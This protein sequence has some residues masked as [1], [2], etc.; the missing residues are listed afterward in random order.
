[1]APTALPINPD[2]DLINRKEKKNLA[3]VVEH[4]ETVKTVSTNHA[5]D[6]ALARVLHGANVKTGLF[7]NLTSKNHD[8]YGITSETYFEMWGKD[9]EDDDSGE[10]AKTRASRYSTLVNAYYNLATDFYEYGW[11]KS[12]HFCRFYPGEEFNSAMKRHEYY[13]ANRLGVEPGMKVLD[14][15]CGVGGPARAIAHLTGANIIGLNNNAY[16]VEKARQYAIQEDLG[17]KLEF[18]K[19]DFMQ[20]PFDDDTFDRVYAVEATCHAPTFEGV[21]AELYRVLKPGGKFGCYEWC[22]TEKY[23]PSDSKQ[24]DIVHRIALGNSLPDV[25]SIQDALDALERVGFELEFHVDLANMGDRIHWYYPLEGDLRQCQTFRDILT[26][27]VMTSVGRFTTTNLCRV[28]E[29]IGI[30]P[31]GTVQT[32][33]MLETAGDSLVEGG[34]AGIFTPMFFFVAKKPATSN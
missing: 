27:L 15:G 28:L 21:Y 7:T 13:L 16:Q 23:D 31:R 17:D 11:G 19:G 3:A 14:A 30:A 10:K 24:K 32:Q 34:R 12:F 6:I 2:Q 29:K 25:R 8:V 20:I 5:E 4:H 26:T 1:M 33:E 18:V 9:A 22:S